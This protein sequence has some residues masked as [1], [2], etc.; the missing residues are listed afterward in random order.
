VVLQVA[1]VLLQF[2]D[3]A[4][5]RLNNLPGWRNGSRSAILREAAEQHL[6]RQQF[7]A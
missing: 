6:E 4:I 5:K 7:P 3:E 2:S 1:T